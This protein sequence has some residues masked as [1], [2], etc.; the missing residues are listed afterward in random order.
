LLLLGGKISDVGGVDDTQFDGCNVC[1]FTTLS[2]SQCPTAME[3]LCGDCGGFSLG[4]TP[5]PEINAPLKVGETE[6]TG[7]AEPG[8]DIFIDVYDAADVLID[9]DTTLVD[10]N[11]DWLAMLANP[12]AIQDSVTARAQVEG[13]CT[14]GISESDLS[15]AIVVLNEPPVL[16]GSGT[17][18]D[19]TENDGQ[20]PIDNNILIVD[21]D[22]TEIYGAIVTLVQNYTPAEDLI[23]FN[24]QSGITGSFDTGTA[25]LTLTGKATLAAYLAALASITY[26]NSSEDP[27]IS[28]RQVSF[29]INDG[30][31]DSNIFTRVIDVISG[32]GTKLK[33]RSPRGFTSNIPFPVMEAP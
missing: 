32:F 3:D 4:S 20:V 27:D 31:D 33:Q 6:I 17:I 16:S 8:A 5:R 1:A 12:L 26:E 9:Q 21:M 19:Y 13:L 15:F 28:P 30:L 22:D 23:V 10:G 25:T 2:E 24:D 29:V 7:T 11:G 14:S 18:L